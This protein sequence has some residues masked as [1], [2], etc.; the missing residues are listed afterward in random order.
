MGKILNRKEL[1]GG[2]VVLILAESVGS[3]SA[4]VANGPRAQDSLQQHAFIDR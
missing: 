1:E 2:R 3:A 4:T